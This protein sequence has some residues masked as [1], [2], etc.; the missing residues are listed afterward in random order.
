GF[1]QAATFSPDDDAGK[2]LNPFLVTFDDAGVDADA[3]THFEFG[4]FL[5]DL[6]ALNRI[7][8]RVHQISPFLSVAA[9]SGRRHYLHSLETAV[10]F[11]RHASG[12][13]RS[14]TGRHFQSPGRKM[15][16]EVPVRCSRAPRPR[17]R[18]AWQAPT[19]QTNRRLPQ[20]PLHLPN[21]D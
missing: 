2:N 1:I 3:V 20:A 5:F 9:V 6:F 10:P 12:I 7:D 21:D 17:C 19:G 8:T 16:P 4:N 18:D 15:Q 13:T 14:E 11:R